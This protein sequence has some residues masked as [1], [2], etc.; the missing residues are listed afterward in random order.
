VPR[1]VD[2]ELFDPARRARASLA[3]HGIADGPVALYVGR[4]SR[5]KNLDVLRAAWTEVHAQRPD[6]RLVVVGEGPRPHALD[7]PGVI[8]TGALHGQA[9]A[10]VFASADVFALPSETE[11]F[12]NVVLE[13]AA[14]GLPALV[15]AA[16]AAH[17]HVIDGITGVVLDGG[18]PAAFA[19]AIVA[20]FDDAP[21]RLAMGRAARIHAARHDL[22][23]AVDATWAIYGDVASRVRQRAAS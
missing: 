15:A 18:D 23:R 16:G 6:A 19:R 12:G 11:T 5:E 22:R 17:E 10:T 1:G 2:L 21:R 20:L 9:L 3:S 8:A 4:L 13:A 14:S 7:G